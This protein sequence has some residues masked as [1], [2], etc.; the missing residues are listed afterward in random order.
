[1]GLHS[2]PK[3]QIP[4]RLVEAV[5]IM[6]DL[7]EFCRQISKLVSVLSGIHRELDDE[8]E[9][10]GMMVRDFVKEVLRKYARGLRNSFEVKFGPYALRFGR[11]EVEILKGGYSISWPENLA[12]AGIAMVEHGEEILKQLER[13]VESERRRA[14]EKI[15]ELR[16]VRDLLRPVLVLEK[17]IESDEA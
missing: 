13:I 11:H 14:S 1:L 2:L 10:T 6:E 9:K 3:V 17:M 12:E 16:K 4:K 7:I 8:M 5:E 15:K